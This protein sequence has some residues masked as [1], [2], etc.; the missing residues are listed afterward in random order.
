[1]PKGIKNAVNIDKK[2]GNQLWQE[3]IKSELKERGGDSNR[4]SENSLSYGF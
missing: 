3:A 4:L 2:N 1:M